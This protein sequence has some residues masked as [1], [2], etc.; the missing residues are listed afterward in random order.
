MKACKIT[1]IL[2]YLFPA[3]IIG[4]LG[5]RFLTATEYFTYHA[6]TAGIDWTAINPGLKLVFLAVFKI[7]GASLLSLCIGMLIMILVPFAKY[8][9]RWSYFTIPIIGMFFWSITLATTLYVTNNTPAEAPWGG[10]LICVAAFL[11]AFA[12]SMIELSM[13]K[14][15]GSEAA[16]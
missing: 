9:H 8:S 15:K 2:L 16:I 7:C 3:I 13:L 6:Q 11:V 4:T 1:A 14:R 12:F 5:V 10:S